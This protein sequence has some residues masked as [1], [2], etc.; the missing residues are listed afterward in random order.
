M[1]ETCDVPEVG[2]S[3]WRETSDPGPLIE[4]LD[5]LLAAGPVD[6]L[7]I[8]TAKVHAG[9]VRAAMER[10]CDVLLT[11][12][13]DYPEHTVSDIERLARKRN[14][15]VWPLHSW[16]FLP[17]AARAAEFATL[18]AL[19]ELEACELRPPT[20]PGVWTRF[21][22]GLLGS[23]A[24]HRL[25]AWALVD[26]CRW[27]LGPPNF[28]DDDAPVQNRRSR[29]SLFWSPHLTVTAA[30]GPPDELAIDLHGD[31][32]TLRYRLRVPSNHAEPVREQL[33]VHLAGIARKIRLPEARPLATALAHAASSRVQGRSCVHVSLADARDTMKCLSKTAPLFRPKDARDSS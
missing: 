2:R 30:M 22:P 15:R 21:L 25:E 14:V 27:L 32:G 13:L 12:P 20:T 5:A 6:I 26:F 10:G 24:T 19:G 17:G 28:S 31:H 9:F 3:G 1:V 4:A 11:P 33:V 29:N 16:R 7:H 23:E 18:G 8:C